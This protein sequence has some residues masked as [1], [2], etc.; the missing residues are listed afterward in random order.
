M[1]DFLEIISLLYFLFYS[2]YEELL[3]KSRQSLIFHIYMSNWLIPYRL[4][5]GYEYLH[6]KFSCV[7]MPNFFVW[8]SRHAA[9]VEERHNLAIMAKIIC[10]STLCGNFCL[11]E[12]ITLTNWGHM[13][14]RDIT[15]SPQNLR[16][17]NKNKACSFQTL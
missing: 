5:A 11:Y 2:I 6:T 14:N 9:T 12:E 13:L 3:R 15:Q 7:N 4:R 8:Q 10:S 1:L 17:E 16:E